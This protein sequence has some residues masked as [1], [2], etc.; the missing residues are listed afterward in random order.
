MSN[1]MQVH[2]HKFAADADVD[3]DRYFINGLN[4]DCPSGGCGAPSSAAQPALSNPFA[5]GVQRVFE[6]VP[7]LR[8][9]GA[10]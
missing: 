8:R 10:A 1:G 3:C 6:F 7:Q 2:S 5:W 4:N 9:W